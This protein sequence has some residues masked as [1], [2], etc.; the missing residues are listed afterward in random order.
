MY[1]VVEYYQKHKYKQKF[2]ATVIG[3]R[4]SPS[5]NLCFETTKY[6]CILNIEIEPNLL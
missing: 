3:I 1:M 2:S 4:S 5:I 6:F